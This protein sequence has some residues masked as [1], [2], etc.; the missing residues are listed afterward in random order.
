MLILHSSRSRYE[1]FN[2]CARFGFIQYH[3]QGRG[4]VKKGKNVFL[5]T[6]QW[7]HKGLEYIFK[8]LMKF[9]RKDLPDDIFGGILSRV[10][11]EYFNDVFPEGQIKAGL[12]DGFALEEEGFVEDWQ[13]TVEKRQFTNQEM[14]QQQQYTFNEQSSL[15]EALLIVFRLRILPVWMSKYRIVT[16]ENDMSFPLVKGEGFEIHQSATIDVVLQDLDSKDLIIVS[17][18]T[19]ST[20]TDT[21]SKQSSHD[22]QGL[23]ETWAFEEYLR[24]HGKKGHVSGVQ[25]LHFLKGQ[26]RET[27]RGSGIYEQKSPL[28]TGYRKIGLEGVEYAHSLY[29]PKPENDSGIGRLGKG[30]ERFNTWDQEGEAVGGVRGWVEMLANGQVF[31]EGD[32]LSEQIIEPEPYNRQPQFVESWLRQT[33]ARELDIARKLFSIDHYIRKKQ[34][35]EIFLD[36]NFPQNNQSCHGIYG[37]DCPYLTVCWGTEEQRWAPVEN[38]EFEFRTPHHKAELIQI[39][40]A[41]TK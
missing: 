7:T 13:G 4:I 31:P 36:E 40:G 38:G 2:R 34:H 41:Q 17:F 1:A 25:M 3:W 32:M 29:Y 24:M 28:T 19:N 18:K 10:K 26:R 15:V 37:R 27:K 8:Y 5:S 6:G 30:W 9:K 22:T 23:S 16:V 11:Q 20:Y 35:L 21:T 39:E 33:K 12:V 14:I